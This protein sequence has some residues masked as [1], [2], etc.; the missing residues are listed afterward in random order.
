MLENSGLPLQGPP[1]PYKLKFKKKGTFGYLCVVHPGMAGKVR[2]VGSKRRI[3]S[4]RKDRRAAARAL[5]S[6]L[7]R[8]QRLTTGLGTEDLDKT[9]QAGNDRAS[10]A[11]IYG[12]FPRNPTYKVGDTV[13]L[14]MPAALTELHTLTFGPTNGKGAYNDVLAT[15][16]EGVAPDQRA[17]YPSEP[18]PAGIPSYDGTNHGNGFY[19]SGILDVDPASP[20]PASTKVTFSGPGTFS[21]ICLIHPFMTNTVH[22]P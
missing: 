1:P 22:H 16:F 19:N 20:L 9:I 11:T 4:A 2:V 14:Q 6:T 5:K 15:S 7:Q 18:P 3:L 8:V 17:I 13:T 12:F 21:L 10:G